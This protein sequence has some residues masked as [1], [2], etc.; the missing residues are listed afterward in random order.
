[1]ALGARVVMLTV[2]ILIVI[3][4]RVV[5]INFLSSTEET[6]NLYRLLNE[7]PNTKHNYTQNNDGQYNDGQHNNFIV[8][9]H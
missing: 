5:E 6:Y 2:V 7:R 8:E 9:S 3:I 1:M 4:Q